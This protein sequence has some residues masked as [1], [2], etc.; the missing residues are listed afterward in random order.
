MPSSLTPRRVSP[1]IGLG[2]SAIGDS[3]NAFAQ[4]DKVLEHYEKKVNEGVLP[5]VRG[6][7]LDGEDQVVRRHILNLM[8]R[9][10]TSWPS[11]AEH[12]VHLSSVPDRLKE[13]VGDGLV[14]TTRTS[15]KITA[16][17]RP[18]I[19]NVCMAFDARLI[20]KQPESQLFSQTV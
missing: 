5:I 18:F 17:G 15:V 16:A 3:W 10:E 9:F 14:E 20:R 7:V 19:R 4:N 12:T 11:A 8:T 6:H 13:M 1:L 2:V